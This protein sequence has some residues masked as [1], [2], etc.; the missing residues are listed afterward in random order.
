MGSCRPEL[1]RW[2]RQLGRLTSAEAGCTPKTLADT[3]QN[4]SRVS[5]DIVRQRQVPD[6]VPVSL[7]MER[8][9]S[10][11]RALPQSYIPLYPL[12]LEGGVYFVTVL[13]LTVYRRLPSNSH[14]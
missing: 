10:E 7:G 2:L 3:S 9:L 11:A 13:E 14:S 8:L 12:A 6:Y 4:L 1:Q 5:E